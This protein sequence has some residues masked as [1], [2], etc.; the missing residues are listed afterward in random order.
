[1]PSDQKIAVSGCVILATTY[2]CNNI[3]DSL[4]GILSC[5]LSISILLHNKINVRS[6]LLVHS[7]SW[8]FHYILKKHRYFIAND[9]FSA[10]QCF[11]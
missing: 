3:R 2:L 9:G 6:I 11:C 1:M 8:E 10:A 5:L 7:K 4:E